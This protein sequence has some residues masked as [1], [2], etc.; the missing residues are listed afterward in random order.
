MRT[1]VL[2]LV[3][4]CF[5]ASTPT[6]LHAQAAASSAPVAAGPEQGS[7]APAFTLPW[8]TKDTIG[9]PDRPFALAEAAGKPVVVAFYP[10]DFTSGCTAEMKT[11]AEQYGELFGPEVVVVGISTDS[12]ATH[13][14][15]AASL[16]LPFKLLSD[17]DQAVAQLYGSDGEKGYDRRTV[18]VIGRDGKIAYRNMHFGAL[19]PTAYAELKAAVAKARG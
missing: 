8:A 10:K 5:V 17:P 12:L 6:V 1:R 9:R 7:P 19:D 18:F 14:R 11:F 15:F 2:A 4:A 13:Q 3:V 16:G